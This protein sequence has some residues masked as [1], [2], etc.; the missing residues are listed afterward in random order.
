MYG[1]MAFSCTWYPKKKKHKP[2]ITSIL[3]IL[4]SFLRIKCTINGIIDNKII[5]K[6]IFAEG[7]GNIFKLLSEE[8]LFWSLKC[9]LAVEFSFETRKDSILSQKWY[10][11]Q[12]FGAQN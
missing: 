6:V 5:S 3:L 2:D 9:R 8:K 11:A 10:K 4:T 7:D 12:K 1:V